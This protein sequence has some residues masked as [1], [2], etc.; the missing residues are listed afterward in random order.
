[1]AQLI[2]CWLLLQEH[3]MACIINASTSAGLVQTADTSGILQF[4]QNGVALPNGGVAPAFFV[5]PS[6]TFTAANATDTKVPFNSKAT[7]GF[8]TNSNFDLTTNYRFT[9][10][11]AGYY[12]IS[13]GLTSTATGTGFC[14]I[15]IYKNSASF[16]QIAYSTAT[17]NYLGA[18]GSALIYFN[19]STD[20]IEFY[21]NQNSGVTATFNAGYLNTWAT[22]CLVRGA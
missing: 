7:V 4:Q 15:K 9:P 16:V 6:G 11:V 22:G 21:V 12:Q 2:I 19:G 14:A 20:Y 18:T 13:A 17:A 10:T 1:M 3:N 8:D 5:Y